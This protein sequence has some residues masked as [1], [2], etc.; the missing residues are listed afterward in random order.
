M[1]HGGR[2]VGICSKWS[3]DKRR[4]CVGTCGYELPFC[5]L[6]VPGGVVC[7][8]FDTIVVTDLV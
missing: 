5:S 7:L 3:G 8:D 6:D 1:A 4:Q 2:S